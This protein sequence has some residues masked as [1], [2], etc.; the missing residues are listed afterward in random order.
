MM[1]RHSDIEAELVQ[2]VPDLRAF[3]RSF[4]RD[5]GR[6][7]D[8]VQE[9]VLKAWS[10]I[11]KFKAGTNLRAWLFT[12]LRNTFISEMRRRTREVEDVDGK[13]AEQLVQRPAQ[14]NAMEL[15]NFRRA[16]AQLPDSQREALILIGASG[17]SCEEAAEICGC[18]PGT[19]KS[20]VN[21][22]R[23]RLAELM[24]LEDGGDV[25]VADTVSAA[26]EASSRDR[27]VA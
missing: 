15:D 16:L 19:V 9:A 18:A 11:D 6:A 7:D 17:F 25:G 8:L 1:A 20:R 27:S 23:T 2:H 10:N 4:H 14:E 12:I 26:V 21:R 5:P 22:A 24:R 3:A 13:F